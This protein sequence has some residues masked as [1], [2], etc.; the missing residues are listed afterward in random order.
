MR[1]ASNS[2]HSSSLGTRQTSA[3]LY[4][5]QSAMAPHSRMQKPASTLHRPSTSLEIHEEELGIARTIGKRK[6]RTPLS[7]CPNPPGHLDTLQSSKLRGCSLRAFSMNSLSTQLDSLSLDH[8]QTQSA[9]KVDVEVPA[10]PSH[11]P[12]LVSKTMLPTETPSPSKS[13]RK[14]PKTLPPLK[15]YLNRTSNEV[16]AWDHDSRLE[17][18]ENM[19]SEFKEKMDGATV[20]SRSLKELIGVYKIRSG[21]SKPFSF[22]CHSRL[23][24]LVTELE[25][26]RTSLATSNTALQT[27]L[28]AI[29]SRVAETSEALEDAKRY[30]F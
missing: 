18:V 11:I 7:S 23:T 5:P 8:G 4:R 21:S 19:C 30:H 22:Q 26:I 25:A 6:R 27:D 24:S 13:P 20:E 28:D 17:E 10:T 1:N 16:I 14:T 15:L 3:L 9:P 12:K 2:S 29:K